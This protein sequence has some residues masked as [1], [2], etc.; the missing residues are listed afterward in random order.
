[1]CAHAQS[2]LAF[3]DTMDCSPPGS[4]V[5]G[6]LQARILESVPLPPPGDLPDPRTDP[7]SPPFPALASG[8]FT[9]EPPEKPSKV[10]GTILVICIHGHYISVKYT[11]EIYFSYNPLILPSLSVSL[12]P[13]L[14]FILPRMVMESPYDF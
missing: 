10:L 1:M 8:F 13:L 6:I 4:N 11:N 7:M 14:S 2:C 12:S 5:R 3:C 9:T